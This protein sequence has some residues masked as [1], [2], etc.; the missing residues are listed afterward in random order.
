MCLE[1][2]LW[3]Y[4][5]SVMNLMR[6]MTLRILGLPGFR[7]EG[8]LEPYSVR[9]EGLGFIGLIGQKGFRSRG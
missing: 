6:G 9:F 8:G 7:A 1:G 4:E 3:G 5:A 2:V